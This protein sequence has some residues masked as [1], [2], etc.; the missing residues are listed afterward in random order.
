M[1][2]ITKEILIKIQFSEIYIDLCNKYCEFDNGGKFTKKEVESEIIRNELQMT[3]SSK[4]KLFY[5]DYVKNNLSIRFILSYKYGFIE[6]FYT[7]KNLINSEKIEGRFNTIATLQNVNFNNL[8]KHKFPIATSL[9]DL[10][11]ILST[12]L[13]LHTD[14]IEKFKEKMG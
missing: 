1:E 3:F 12:I 10:K 9:E 8:V 14:F 13:K 4:E 5:K 6:C 11:E 7:I 2:T